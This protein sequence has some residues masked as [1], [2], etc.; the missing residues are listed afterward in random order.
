MVVPGPGSLAPGLPSPQKVLKCILRP[1][2]FEGPCRPGWLCRWLSIITIA[3]VFL[4][5]LKETTLQDPRRPR[6]YCLTASWSRHWMLPGWAQ[7]GGRRPPLTPHSHPR[8]LTEAHLSAGSLPRPT[9][10][11]FS[12][13]FSLGARA[14]LTVEKWGKGAPDNPSAPSL[15]FRRLA[16]NSLSPHP[17]SAAGS[18]HTYTSQGQV[19]GC[20]V[21]PGLAQATPSPPTTPG[22]GRHAW[23]PTEKEQARRFGGDCSCGVSA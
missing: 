4:L 12:L 5:I 10:A 17:R 16:R 11:S 6:A 7:K 9:E 2:W 20:E 13:G 14:R 1:Q 23:Q 8:P 18:S 19:S 21:Q 15:S 3:F 22:S